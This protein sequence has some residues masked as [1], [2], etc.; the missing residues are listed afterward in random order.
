MTI[1]GED[2]VRAL[3]YIETEVKY[4]E[5]ELEKEKTKYKSK[6]KTLAEHYK[7]YRRNNPK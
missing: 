2:L 3:E 1:N 4:Y 7:N 6:L 5:R